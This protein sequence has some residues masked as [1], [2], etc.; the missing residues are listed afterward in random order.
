[1]S[2]HGRIQRLLAVYDDLQ[3]AER[4]Q[5]DDH[6]HACAR[7]AE[8]LSAYRAMDRVL[9]ELVTGQARSLAMRP[10]RAF[11]QTSSPV[12]RVMP[13]PPTR[14]PQL[15]HKAIQPHQ[16][17]LRLVSAVVFFVLL[18]ILSALFGG[19]GPFE[20]PVMASTPTVERPVA[21][22]VVLDLPSEPTRMSPVHGVALARLHQPLTVATPAPKS[23]QAHWQLKPTG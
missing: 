1:M 21:T 8:T 3:Q 4:D 12:R 5:V 14:L 9:H 10:A 11:A 17:R 13:S 7:C 22:P 23:E 18:M 16:Y 19:W 20:E 15:V 6:L 2:E